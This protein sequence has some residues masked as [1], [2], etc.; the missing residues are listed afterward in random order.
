MIYICPFSH[1]YIYL[2]A[3]LLSNFYIFEQDDFSLICGKNFKWF[4]KINSKLKDY[5]KYVRNQKKKSAYNIKFN[6][7]IAYSI[8]E[9]G[10][11]K[12]VESFGF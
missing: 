6:N 12:S 4:Y 9:T 11:E 2:S 3:S 5:S 10:D 7:I 8:E 1:N